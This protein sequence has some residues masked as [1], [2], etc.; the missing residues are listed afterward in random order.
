[1]TLISFSLILP[2]SL[3]FI[4]AE[5]Y[6]DEGMNSH[7]P[8]W[9]TS[10]VSEK[11]GFMRNWF[12]NPCFYPTA[13]LPS[14]KSGIVMVKSERYIPTDLNGICENT[15][16]IYMAPCF[17]LLWHN[18]QWIRNFHRVVR[19][20]RCKLSLCRHFELWLNKTGRSMQRIHVFA[21][22]Q[23]H[24]VINIMVQFVDMDI[25]SYFLGDLISVCEKN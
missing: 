19:G 11:R 4:F 9:L 23:S 3:E 7:V 24:K 25:R 6:T 18:E 2:V 17:S 20:H 14:V 21:P 15:R 13:M 5:L 22:L 16:R 8:L 12:T 1:M 10:C